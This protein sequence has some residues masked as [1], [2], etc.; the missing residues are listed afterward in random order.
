[1][2]ARLSVS[3]RCKHSLRPEGLASRRAQYHSRGLRARPQEQAQARIKLA[4]SD[5]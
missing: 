1:M 5:R 2:R 4:H 3:I